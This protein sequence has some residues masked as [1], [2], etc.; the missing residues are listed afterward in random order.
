MKTIYVNTTMNR[1]SRGWY[2]KH[3][4]K[5]GC[6]HVRVTEMVGLPQQPPWLISP[7]MAIICPETSRS[8]NRRSSA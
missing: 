7:L 1:V 8:G 2:Q 3:L 4:R 6:L 5:T